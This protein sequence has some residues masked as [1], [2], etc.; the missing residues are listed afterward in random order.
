MDQGD[1][2]IRG[3]NL[4]E[5]TWT[6]PGLGVSE[7]PTETFAAIRGLSADAIWQ[8]IK[9]NLFGSQNVCCIMELSDTIDTISGHPKPSITLHK[10]NII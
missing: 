10:T 9:Y 5:H 8:V 1:D 2:V 4:M 7:K 6:D 3:S